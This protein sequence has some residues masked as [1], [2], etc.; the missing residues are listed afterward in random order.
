MCSHYQLAVYTFVTRFW[1]TN[2]II[3]LILVFREI[4]ISI[5]ETTV[6]FLC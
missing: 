5:I 6:I 2:Q 3:T 4:P 1:K